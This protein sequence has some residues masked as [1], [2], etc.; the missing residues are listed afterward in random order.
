MALRQKYVE[1]LE[2]ILPKLAGKA[3]LDTDE[4]VN[5]TIFPETGE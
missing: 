1:M 2:T 3:M 5:L 4:P